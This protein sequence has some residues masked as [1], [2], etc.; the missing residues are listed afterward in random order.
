MFDIPKSAGLTLVSCLL[1][2][3]VKA[4]GNIDDDDEASG[5]E[6]VRP[7]DSDFGMLGEAS[8]VISVVK[9]ERRKH[10]SKAECVIVIDKSLRFQLLPASGGV[11]LAA[12][13][14]F[15]LRN[16]DCS[17]GHSVDG[18]RPIFRLVSFVLCRRISIHR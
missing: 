11:H 4:D 17:S 15:R 12:H 6:K 9:G 13:T 7:P 1:N 3:F 16:N 18:L 8:A 14:V 10:V 2:R 5:D